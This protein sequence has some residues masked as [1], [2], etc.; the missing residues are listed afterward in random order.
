[1][2]RTDLVPF[3]GLPPLPGDLAWNLQPLLL[4]VMLAGLA[5]GWRIAGDRR[6]F[7]AGWAV[8]AAMLLSP[9]CGLAVALFSAR[10]GQH[11]GV[12]LLAAPLIAA[13]LRPRAAAPRE[14]ALAATAFGAALWF[15]HLPAPYR[16]TFVSDGA[17]WAMH[18]SLL[19]T[20]VWFWQ[21]VLR[22]VRAD[23]ALL[24]GLATASQMGALGAFLTFAPRPL[25][26]PHALTT[27]PWGLTPLE[28]Q[29]L[30]GLLMWVPG[31]VAFAA[32]A[33]WA[34]SRPLFADAAPDQ[35]PA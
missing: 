22:A 6:L 7:L 17:W 28:D 3:C 13:S 24:S 21:G 14:L 32:L 18:A 4:G 20:A 26:A 25:F 16:W 11:L 9:L 1:M 29:Q 15:W 23:A 31:G 19:G 30:G 12:M 34:L 2:N 35:G 5:A 27:L 8:L 33:L 10:V